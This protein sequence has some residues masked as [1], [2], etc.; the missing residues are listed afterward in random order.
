MIKFFSKIAEWLRRYD[1]T[2]NFTC[3]VCGREVFAGER[4]CAACRKT[5]PFNDRL[6]CPYCGR[7]VREAG[8]CLECKQSRPAVEKARSAFVHE[9]E[10]AAL[11]LRFKKGSKY[12]F[13]TAENAGT[14]SRACSPRNF[15]GGAESSF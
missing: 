5:L 1:E 9:G 15:R 13:R 12:L 8:V 3:D 6:I 10:A 2:H 11:V 4:V 7:R 14:I